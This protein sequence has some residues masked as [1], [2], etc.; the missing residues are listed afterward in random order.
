M[1]GRVDNVT[2]D[3]KLA[4]IME[5]AGNLNALDFLLSPTHFA[6]D[7]LAIPS[8]AL[9]MPLSVFVLDIDGGGESFDSVA[10]DSSQLFVESAVVLGPP[11]QFFEYSMRVNSHANVSDH[12]PYRFKVFDGEIFSTR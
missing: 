5:I 12:C 11:G 7:D 2:I 9:R 1:V 8:D 4:D 10:V 3:Y 6:C